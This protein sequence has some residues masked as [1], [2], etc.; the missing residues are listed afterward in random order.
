MPST[1]HTHTRASVSKQYNVVLVK[2]GDAVRLT[3]LPRACWKVMAAYRWVYD[4][5]ETGPTRAPTL[6]SSIG[7][8]LS[9]LFNCLYL[10]HL[11]HPAFQD[12]VDMLIHHKSIARINEIKLHVI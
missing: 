7:L 6:L 4:C 12:I 11:R 3:R 1:S 8:P 9:L 2:G 5:I 10:V